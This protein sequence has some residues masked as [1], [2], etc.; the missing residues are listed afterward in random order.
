MQPKKFIFCALDFGNIKEALFFANKIKDY[1]GGLKLGL[2]FFVKNGPEG[3]RK[4]KKL[5]LPIF[6]D[7]KFNDIPNTVKNAAINAI[8]LEPEF[9]TVHLNGGKA[10]LDEVVR[11]K[12]KTKIIGVSLL[13]SLTEIDLLSFGIKINSKQYINKLS[14]I[15]VSSGLDGIVSSPHE[16]VFLKNK[17]PKDFIFV[18]PGIR[19]H[20]DQSNDQKRFAS[21]GEAIKLGSSMLVIGRSI[22][23]SAS[24]IDTIKK[25]VKDIEEKN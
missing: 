18:T 19:L 3:V 5:G 21:P 15:G 11:I 7:L 4:V 24:P 13:T 10:M 14:E 8:K 25:I 16:V 2:E 20:G 17:M 22:T 9:L 6:L 12:K 1:V 23:K